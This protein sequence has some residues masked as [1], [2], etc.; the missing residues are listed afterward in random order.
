M[1]HHFPIDQNMFGRTGACIAKYCG[2]Y[3]IQFVGHTQHDLLHTASLG[4]VLPRY[5]SY[6]RL[7]SYS[8]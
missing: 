1:Q 3:R 8:N 7:S 2:I 5:A 4:K 6:C